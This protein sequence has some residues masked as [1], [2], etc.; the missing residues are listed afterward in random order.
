MDVKIF[1]LLFTAEEHK[2]FIPFCLALL[3]SAPFL[4]LM[5]LLYVSKDLNMKSLTTSPQREFVHMS[6]EH[7]MSL[8]DHL[9][10]D[11][12]LFL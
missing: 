12:T 2:T 6:E 1:S 8:S 4:L 11:W 5:F 3:S 10:W 7:R 9:R